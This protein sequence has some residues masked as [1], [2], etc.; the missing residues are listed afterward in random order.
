MSFRTKLQ[1]VT[2]EFGHNLKEFE[3]YVLCIHIDRLITVH[4]LN[5]R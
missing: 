3:G 1:K 2:S 4:E 5:A